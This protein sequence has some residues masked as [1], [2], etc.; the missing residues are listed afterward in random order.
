MILAPALN[1]LP[2]HPTSFAQRSLHIPLPSIQYVTSASPLTRPAFDCKARATDARTA[3]GIGPPF[4]E[5]RSKQKAKKRRKMEIL[6]LRCKTLGQ[7]LVRLLE[8]PVSPAHDFVRKPSRL[9][10]SSQETRERDRKSGW[11]GA[12]EEGEEAGGS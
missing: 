9:G 2:S 7:L 12:T 11:R 5:A 8:P 6:R 4:H 1:H 3:S 10:P